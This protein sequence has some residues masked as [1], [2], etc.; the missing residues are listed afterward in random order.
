MVISFGN[1]PINDIPMEFLTGK[2]PNNRYFGYFDN[3][4]TVCDDEEIPIYQIPIPTSP[5]FTGCPGGVLP[6]T[7]DNFSLDL[8]T[9]QVK[10]LYYL[11]CVILAFCYYIIIN[12]F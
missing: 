7:P 3:G 8:Y 9:I 11:K 4:D 10:A 1:A 5:L 6:E 12:I 2:V